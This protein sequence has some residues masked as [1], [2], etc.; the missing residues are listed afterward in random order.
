VTVR[1]AEIADGIAGHT[2]GAGD[3]EGLRRGG[4]DRSA[5][6]GR[7]PVIL[8]NPGP[9]SACGTGFLRWREVAGDVDD[10]IQPAVVPG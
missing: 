5:Q 8:E 2:T 7:R 10:E 4:R 3:L 1:L 6:S 9:D